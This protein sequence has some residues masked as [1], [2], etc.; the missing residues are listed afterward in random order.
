VSDV[1]GNVIYDME[2][3]RGREKEI[4]A[5]ARD[6]VGEWGRGKGVNV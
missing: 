1:W 3:E 2:A 4:E 5:I 6:W